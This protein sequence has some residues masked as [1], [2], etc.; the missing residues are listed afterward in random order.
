MRKDVQFNSSSGI[1]QQSFHRIDVQ[2]ALCC[3]QLCSYMGKGVQFDSSS[4]INQQSCHRKVLYAV[5][6]CAVIW[7]RVSNL[8]VPVVLTSNLVTV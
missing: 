7:G 1:N 3:L 5:Y 8:T 6:S 4:D 2:V